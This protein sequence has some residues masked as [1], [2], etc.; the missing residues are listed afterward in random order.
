MFESERSLLRHATAVLLGLSREAVTTASRLPGKP[1]WRGP[2]GVA[3]NIGLNVTRES[4]RSLLD[5]FSSLPND[6]FR[7]AEGM[8]EAACRLV[9]PPVVA[10]LDVVAEPGS[11]GGVSGC[12][13]RPRRRP[14]NAS[15]LYFHGGGYVGTTPIMYAAFVA[16][17]AQRTT[18]DVFVVVAERPRK[19][20]VG[21][22]LD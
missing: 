1:L 15:I 21:V 9:M 11:L 16:F 5:L 18:S 20:R 4:V 12:W 19:R 10:L 2:E 17:L 8:L 14:T 3:A 22:E 6:E 7:V 13:Y